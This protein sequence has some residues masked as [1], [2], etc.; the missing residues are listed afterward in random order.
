MDL[1][2]PA[3]A[4]ATITATPDSVSLPPTVGENTFELAIDVDSSQCAWAVSLFPQNSSFNSITFSADSGSGDATI[5]VTTQQDPCNAAFAFF[6]VQLLDGSGF[7]IA[8]QQVSV[9]QSSTLACADL[10]ITGT[11]QFAPQGGEGFATLSQ[12]CFSC[13]WDVTSDSDWIVVTDGSGQGGGNGYGPQREILFTVLP[14]GTTSPR[15]GRLLAQNGLQVLIEQQA[16]AG[17]DGDFAWSPLGSGMNFNSVWAM[18]VFDDGTG[19]ALYVGGS[20][21]AAGGVSAAHVA[22]W[23]GA[24]WTPLG[25]G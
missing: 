19:P 7:P 1:Q 11:T 25:S 16:A 17:C 22:R 23:D 13:D 5:L 24:S 12:T 21:T 6:Q 14:N 10:S 2:C 20:F 4:C 3:N 8:S 9:G 15:S 18:V